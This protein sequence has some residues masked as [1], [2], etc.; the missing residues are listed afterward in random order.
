MQLFRAACGFDNHRQRALGLSFREF[1]HG[2]SSYLEIGMKQL[3]FAFLLLFPL[4][5]VAVAQD[6]ATAPQTSRA[7]VLDPEA[8]RVTA[9]DLTSGLT[10]AVSLNGGMTAL[11]KMAAYANSN[12]YYG[13]DTLLLT[14]EGTRLIRLRTGELGEPIFVGGRKGHRPQEKSTA[15]IIDAKTMQ[16]VEEADL[17]WGLYNY[18]LT[19]DQKVLLTLTFGDQSQ[20]HEETLPSELVATDVSSGQVLGRLT[21][22]RPPSACLLSKDSSTAVLLF[23]QQQQKGEPVHPAELQFVSIGKL[24]VLGKI[25]LDSVT[26]MTAM[27]P[28]GEYLYLMEKGRPSDNPEKNVNGRIRVISM[29]EMKVTAVL[30]AG[31]DPKGMFIDRTAGQLLLLSEGAPVKGQKEVD[32]ELR[33]I[34]GASITSL[35]P[36]AAGP[37]FMRFSPD[38][39]RLYVVCSKELSAIDYS[40]LHELGRIPVGGLISELAFS[41]DGNR[42]FALFSG[43][44]RLL[45]L[46]LQG[47]KPG[48]SVTTGRGGIKFAK[49]LTVVAAMAAAATDTYYNNGGYGVVNY[50][51]NFTGGPTNTSIWVRP[52]GAFVYV[53]NIETNDVTIV[54]TRNSSVVDKIAAGGWRLHPLINGN[55]LAV[56]A[57][58]KL[59]LIDTA[60][61]KALP[62][63]LFDK[64]LRDFTLAPD[65]QTAY[66]F[67]GGTL[68]LMNGSTGEV[69]SRVDGFKWPRVVVFADK[70]N[71]HSVPV[72]P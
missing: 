44:S 65:G 5:I 28:S 58:N 63:I 4:G 64:D 72:K 22:Q 35:L 6:A 2:E 19:P 70:E 56:V 32:G 59:H 61:Q 20:K 17:G 55:I 13:V 67:V 11:E 34:R 45:L 66:A 24:T 14:H 57:R 23:A 10:T 62:D 31:S 37:R 16:A 48:D 36:V 47:L 8:Q 49:D 68:I 33:V 3:S 50:Y 26:N 12:I 9:V 60:T 25:M 40:S 43:S 71:V 30:D 27:S 29:K 53:L 54:D 41:P 52:D 51:Q 21:L 42:G 1:Q 18:C 46:D 69:Q 15:T 39:K 38:R 7:Y